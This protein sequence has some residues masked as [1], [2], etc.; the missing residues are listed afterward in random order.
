MN[1][2]LAQVDSSD[3]I[4]TN[5]S[6]YKLLV[7]SILTSGWFVF[8]K[9]TRVF[10]SCKS[11]TRSLPVAGLVSFIYAKGIVNHYVLAKSKTNQLDQERKNNLYQYKSKLNH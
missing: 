4:L 7:A 10:S 5:T 8:A 11:L 3:S 2:G 6:F 1:R 9:Q